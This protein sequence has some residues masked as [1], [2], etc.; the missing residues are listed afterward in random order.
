MQSLEII[1][2]LTRDPV[3]MDA[4]EGR[5]VCNFTLAVDSYLGADKKQTDYFCVS[6]WGKLAESCQKHLKKG[7]SA[8]VIGVVSCHGYLGRDGLPK[9]AMDVRADRVKFLGAPKNAE[10]DWDFPL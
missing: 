10:E 1:G 5:Q 2:N 7:H 4:G 9:A 3:T 8:A 6:A